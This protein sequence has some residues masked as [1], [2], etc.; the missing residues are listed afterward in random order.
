MANSKHISQDEIQYIVDVESSKAQQEIHKLEKESSKLR[1]EN[2][3][4]LNQMIQLEAQGKKNTSAY[5]ALRK[6]YTDNSK[7]ISEL[8]SKIGELTSKL[9]V[10]QMTMKQLKK[11]ARD[12]RRNL[13]DTS[14]ATNPQEYA[15]LEGRLK[16]VTTRMSELRQNA[17]SLNEVMTEN[18]TQGIMM[19]NVLT[20]LAEYLGNTAKKVKGF[21]SSMA[22]DGIE[23]ARQ[24]DG[25]TKAFNELNQPDLLDNLRAATKGTVNDV[26]LM[27]SAVQ[28]NDFRIPLEDLGKYLSFAQLKAQ[29]TG[30]TV[31]SLTNSIVVGLGRK[32]PQILDNLGISS[33]ELKEKMKET[34]DMAS[35]VSA[36]VEKQ[37]KEAG[38]TYIS[39]ADRSMQA[40]V[41]LQNAQK[42]LG[43][44]LL[45]L[46]EQY[47]EAYGAMQI[48][49]IELVKWMVQH[50]EVVVGVVLAITGLTAATIKQTGVLTGNIIATKGAAAAHA[51][52]NQVATT[53]K[54]LLILL[55]SGFYLLTGRLA[56]AKTAWA[57]L[58]ATMK[59]NLIYLAATA[60]V[61]LG[62]AL[63][64]WSKRINAVSREQRILNS[65]RDNANKKMEEERV[66]IDMLTKRIHDNTLSI[67]ERKLAI[68][69]LQSIVPDY[70]AKLSAEGRV[71]DENTKALN[72]YL[73]ALKEKALLEGAKQQLQELGKQKAALILQQQQ[74]QQNLEDLKQEQKEY[75][76]NNSGR[77]QTSGGGVAAGST[78]ATANYTANIAA[79]QRAISKTG[80]K[81]AVVDRSLNAIGKAFGQKMFETG[82]G[83]KGG[84][85]VS[86]SGTGAGSTGGRGTSGGSTTID[87]DTVL[88]E[89]YDDARAA[90][91]KK[92]Q[93]FY[94]RR[95]LQLKESL[96]NRQMTQEQY[97]TEMNNLEML[98]ANTILSVEKTYYDESEGLAFKDQNKKKKLQQ[99]YQGYV[100]KA[101]KE[102]DAAR[103][104]AEESYYQALDKITEAGKTEQQLS[105]EQKQQAEL[106]V[107]EV[108]YKTT[109]DRAKLFGEEDKAVT[110]AYEQAKA[111]IIKKYAEQNAQAQLQAR[112]K[113]GLVSDTERL[114][115]ELKAIKDDYDKKL[116]SRDQYEQA[117]SNKEKE[118]ADKRRQQ[119]IQLGVERQS[120]YEQQLAQQKAALDQGLISQEEYEKGVK[121]IRKK[122]W[123]EAVQ[124]YSQLFGGTIS[125]IQDAEMAN[126]DAKYDA[127]IEAARQAGKDTTDL[128]NKK[129][130][131]KLKIQKKYADVN[132]AI[133]AS[134]IIAST[135]GA[136]MKALEQL[137]PIA[138]PV[139]AALM[140]VTGAAQLAAANAE[141][142]KV[143]RMTLNGS[144]SSSAITSGTRVATG[145]ENGGSIDVEREQD[146]KRFHASY[147]PN[148][149]GYIDRPTVIVGEGPA[150]RSKEWVASNAALN[151]PTVAPLID[152]I[153]RA[154]RVGQISTLDMRKYLMQRQVRGL[155]GG[156]SASPASSATTAP[157]VIAPSDAQLMQRIC[158]VLSR[159]EE[160]PIQAYV[161]LDDFD[162]KQ[163]MRDQARRIGSKT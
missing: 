124:Y 11:E 144:S 162:A 148:K 159:M 140:G 153:D 37:L 74:Q 133:K 56:K 54:G 121:E 69:Q 3:Q 87:P 110:E 19:G 119:R 130:N 96:A 28:A 77:P 138:G 109:L 106:A 111:N 17:K 97:D 38:D 83:S 10:N 51:L 22:E 118:Y 128:E 105:L 79:L 34:G 12:L 80:D 29:Q 146:G 102:A 18:A 149:R 15:I 71:Y 145:F 67:K 123:T 27:K 60:V 9:D 39:A 4:R 127:E 120:E 108:Y 31:E 113:Y 141:R 107:L 147:D 135:A 63:L 112:E 139:A 45:P 42:A 115:Q 125:A 104:V 53:G 90:A 32:S 101:Q 14:Q 26:E 33:S 47:E 154:Q 16:E 2:K 150:G 143:K 151:N 85:N 35:A 75:L 70:T 61:A 92:W 157:A 57:G 158:D 114:A 132:F 72:R 137:G 163:K 24:A 52:W 129:A 40:T 44:E 89:Q 134:E 160:Q 116:L 82:S 78:F 88:S 156:G 48:K 100:E 81:L 46:S 136:I 36:I 58:N 84:A 117:V 142:Q 64:T 152:I 155:A 49:I 66:K 94:E 5:Q 55:Q 73:N 65:I 103:L 122:Y 76:R 86:S 131:E 50:R 95:L 23:M 59:T 161:A 1:S 91:L 8:T 98:N 6:E 41:K 99:R 68:E 25:I 20:K 13:E 21:V 62:A 30:Q 7:K 43:D 93:D 126:V